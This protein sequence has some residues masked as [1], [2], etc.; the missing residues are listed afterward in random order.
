M[1]Y[2]GALSKELKMVKP[3]SLSTLEQ[4]VI[5]LEVF[6]FE[7]QEDLKKEHYGYFK[8]YHDPRDKKRMDAELKI[9]RA[10]HRE[11]RKKERMYQNSQAGIPQWIKIEVVANNIRQYSDLTCEY[12]KNK[13]DAKVVRFNQIKKENK[14][15]SKNI[16]VSCRFCHHRK[17]NKTVEVFTKELDTLLK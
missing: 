5:F 9:I 14:I 8:S 17:Y 1:S 15:L 2:N 12:C 11:K 7:E 16:C 4:C 6:M 3:F 10:K 13:I